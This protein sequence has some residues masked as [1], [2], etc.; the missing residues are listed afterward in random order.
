MFSRITLVN[1][2]IKER[3]TFDINFRFEKEE[4]KGSFENIV[5]AE[6]K[7]EK[8]NYASPFMRLIKTNGIRPFRISKYCLATASLYP[9]LKQ[10]N[11]KSKFLHINQL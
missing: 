5:I 2:K 10:N 1:K 6:V 4:Q 9:E 3:L 7:Q 8:V 11:F